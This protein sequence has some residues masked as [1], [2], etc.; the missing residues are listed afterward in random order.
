[1]SLAMASPKRESIPSPISTTTTRRAVSKR[2]VGASCRSAHSRCLPQWRESST[3]SAP[4]TSPDTVEI[5][6]QVGLAGRAVEYSRAA[7]ASSADT[8]G[9]M[10]GEWSPWVAET[11]VG[12]VGKS[13]FLT[14]CES[15]AQS[16]DR[17][18]DCGP[19]WHATATRPSIPLDAMAVSAASSDVRTASMEPHDGRSAIRRPR[20]HTSVA[21]VLQL[22]LP[23]KTAATNSPSEWPMTAKGL[24]NLASGQWAAHIRPRAYSTAKSV[25][26]AY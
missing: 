14:S 1:M 12:R 17:T 3:S 25:M 24:M 26:S 21:A 7:R 6:W 22:M 11:R 10:R 13:S 23:E 5:Q 2:E 19:L 18:S 8:I 4:I 16:P 15:A 9:A 20:S